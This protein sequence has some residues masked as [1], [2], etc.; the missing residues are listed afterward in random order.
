MAHRFT[1]LLA[2]LLLF[3]LCVFPHRATARAVTEEDAARAAAAVIGRMESAEPLAWGAEVTASSLTCRSVGRGYLVSAA[4]GR[5]ALVAADDGDTPVLGYGSTAGAGS[6]PAALRALLSSVPGAYPPAGASGWETVPQL[7]ATAHHQEAPYN[8]NC[9]YYTRDD[10]MVSGAR[11]VVGCVATAMEQIVTYYRR[12]VTLLDTLHGWETAHYK[13]GDA[14][15]GEMVDT[16]LILGNYDTEAYTDAQADAVARLSYYLGLAAHM[17]WG[18]TSSGASS[19]RLVEPLQR[20]FGYKYARRIDSYDYTPA[21]YWNLIAAEIAARRPVYYAGSTMQTSGHAFVLDGLDADGFLH[22]NWGDGGAYDGYFRLDV[23]CASQPAA[24]RKDEYVGSGYFCNQEAIVCCPDEVADQLPAALE[25]T[26]REIAVENVAFPVQ[27]MTGRLTEVRV[28]LRN[29]ADTPLTTSFALLQNLPADTALMEQASWL[30]MTG[31]TLAAGESCTL[32]LHAKLTASGAVLL[33]LTPDGEQTI[34]SETLDVAAG[35]EQALSVSE[36]EI[37]FPDNTT[38]SVSLRVANTSAA[39]RAAERFVYD[40]VED[41]TTMGDNYTHYLYL[42]PE[43]SVADNV[44][45]RGLTPGRG[46][47][48]NIRQPWPVVRTAHFTMPAAAGIAAPSAAT[49]GGAGTPVWY[50]IAGQRVAAPAQPGVYL[51]RDGRGAA[52]KVMR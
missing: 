34:W 25:R 49:P 36:P 52:V 38:A 30:A 43:E 42:A 5:F 3:P 27:P 45:F 22:V 46:Y 47:T 2:P 9:P 6:I 14:L 19:A 17:G 10:G 37:S 29:T 39:E 4:D 44:A 12:P 41:G 1:R 40:L 51:R 7:L 32:S 21:D 23:L 11:C 16:R 50:N 15:P 18:E 20:A 26:G 48:L 8:N 35:G 31:C 28:T 24:A 13:V 33:S